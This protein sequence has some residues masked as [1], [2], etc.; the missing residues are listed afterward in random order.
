MEVG[1]RQ[2]INAFVQAFTVLSGLVLLDLVLTKTVNQ[3]TCS[4]SA[5]LHK[6][7]IVEHQQY[8][9]IYKVYST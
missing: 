2:L 9:V 5:L 6:P 8:D 1:A 4:A 7:E 3:T